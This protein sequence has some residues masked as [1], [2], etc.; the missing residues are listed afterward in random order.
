MDVDRC[1]MCGKAIAEGTQVCQECAERILG[2]ES[3]KQLRDIA[4]VLKIT[5]ETDKN[6]KI[7]VE[8]LL[9]IA[10][11]LERKGRR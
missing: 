1:A 11:R 3:A 5:E 10:D 7:S 2:K 8:A 4:D 9:R 6:I